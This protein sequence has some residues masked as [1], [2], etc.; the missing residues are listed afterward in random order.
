MS[1]MPDV[2]RNIMSFALTLSFAEKRPFC[3]QKIRYRL[4]SES[5][6][7][8][9][10]FHIR[11]FVW[12]AADNP[13]LLCHDDGYRCVFLPRRI[14]QLRMMSPLDNPPVPD[15][16]RPF[17]TL[18]TPPLVHVGPVCSINIPT[19][20]TFGFICILPMIGPRHSA[21]TAALLAVNIEVA[22]FYGFTDAV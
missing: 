4:I 10:R 5:E 8:H 9:Y 14:C 11:Y 18:G 15:P 13:H 6:I 19:N 16:G 21:M 22:D 1:I 17:L 3:A 12:P 2:T 20:G 7:S